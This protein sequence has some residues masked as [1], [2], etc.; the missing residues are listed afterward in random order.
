MAGN[1]QAAWRGIVGLLGV[2]AGLCTIFALVVTVAEGW[3][4]QAQ[5]KWPVATARV[6]RCGLHPTSTSRRNSYYIVC[7]LSYVVGGEEM[8]TRATSRTAPGPGVW[9]YP[10]N[11]IGP[12]QE[13]LDKHPQGTSIAMHY[14]P[15]N[16][17]K[18][19]PVAADALPGRPR[20]PNNLKLLGIAAM[21]C[22][23]LLALSR[24]VSR[25]Q[26]R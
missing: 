20:T 12:L 6:E 11:Q 19:V 21:S 23:V 8:M 25:T 5:A 26:S 10:P 15:G 16:P 24:I 4:E 22:F 7:Q 18:A 3:Q 2:F 1:N 13:W 14:D 9:Q 17:R